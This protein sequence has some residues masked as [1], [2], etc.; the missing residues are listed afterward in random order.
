MLMPVLRSGIDP[1]SPDELLEDSLMLW[2]A[3]LSHAPS[4]VGQLLEYFPCLLEILDRTFDHLKISSDIIEDYIILGGTEFLSMHASTVAGC[5]DLVVGN[6]SDRGLLAILPVIDV[7]V[8]CFPMEVPQFMNNIIQKIIVLCLTG[9]DEHDPSKTAVKASSAAILA[10]LLVTNT[11][12]LAQVT[13][14]PSLLALL[15]KNGFP[16]EENVLLCMVDIWADKVDNVTSIQRRTFALALS[17]I[18]T[19]RLPQVLDKLDH[20]LCACATVILG[21]N[22]DLTEEESSSDNLSSS[23]PQYQSKEFRRRQIKL[24]DPIYQL[25]LENSVRDNL[26]TCSALHGESF[27]TTINRMDPAALAQLKQALKMT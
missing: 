1:N 15:Q 10:R 2:E 18:L 25:S 6:V 22:E 20:I 17:L 5:F 24:S 3:T 12:Y 4:M 26:Q 16:S 21:G 19:L 14:E 9:G 7:I 11:N 8:Q 27:N 13:S 23:R